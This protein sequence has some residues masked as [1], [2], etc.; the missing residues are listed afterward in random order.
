[1]LTTA[2][3][4]RI[5]LSRV[6]PLLLAGVVCLAG[7]G[8]LTLML[9]T[10][11]APPH[12]LVA[13]ARGGGTPL[14]RLIV[15]QLRLPRL[16]LALLAGAMLGLSG[17]LL[18][19][20]MRNPLGGPELLGVTSGAT[21]IVAAITLLHLPV[22]LALVPWLA[23]AGGLAAGAVVVLSVGRLGDPIRLVLTGAALTAL[24]NAGI[25]VLISY[26]NTNDIAL[27]YLF[28]VGSLANRTWNYVRL[29]LPWAIVG[30]PA[31]LLCARA[32][33]LLQLGDDVARGLGLP[34]GR[35]RLLTLALGAALVAAVVAVAGPIAF[36]ALLAP[37]LARRLLRTSDARQVLPLAALLGA[38]LLSA[39]DLL[40]RRAFAPL[41]L[42]VGAF[43]TLIGGPILVVLLRRRLGARRGAA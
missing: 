10:P 40:A 28:L 3:A 15:T 24:L 42:P 22:E 23:L 17:T 30:V 16:V 39:A 34:V 26:G 20:T 43:T 13:I 5:R 35:V 14:A 32:L 18:Q 2:P 9:G 33:N 31:A 38:L 25:F 11:A 27:L 6:L 41:D 29:V 19:D 21:I 37:H 36:I 1:M 12:E 8:L 7:I 4:T